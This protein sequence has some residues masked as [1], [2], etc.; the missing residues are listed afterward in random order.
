M[1]I[2]KDSPRHCR[3]RTVHHSCGESQTPHNGLHAHACEHEHE[4]ENTEHAHGCKLKKC[5]NA[6][7]WCSART[8]PCLT[9]SK[10]VLYLLFLKSPH[11][12]SI[13]IPRSHIIPLWVNTGKP[14]VQALPQ[15]Q[16]FMTVS[17]PL[18]HSRVC[19][20]FRTQPFRRCFP[21]K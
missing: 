6:T 2:G 19:R 11:A 5:N 1:R 14:W 16:D 13:S 3:I 7:L 15:P 12:Y 21:R 9:S 4:H 10:S 8:S 20:S 18:S 17:Y